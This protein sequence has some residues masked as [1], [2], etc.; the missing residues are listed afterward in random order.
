MN[1]GLI[2]QYMRDY[3]EKY[4]FEYEGEFLCEK[5]TKPIAALGDKTLLEVLAEDGEDVV[6]DYLNRQTVRSGEPLLRIPS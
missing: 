3:L 6:V 5:V 4:F 2:P 1:Y